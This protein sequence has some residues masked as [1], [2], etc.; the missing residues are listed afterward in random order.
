MASKK[1]LKMLTDH[2]GRLLEAHLADFTYDSGRGVL[3]RR[4]GDVEQVVQCL[5]LPIGGGISADVSFFVRH[6]A[7]EN[8]R[9]RANKPDRA[10]EH[11]Y[12]ASQSLVNL[13]K[14]CRKACKHEHGATS[15]GL[16]KGA[17]PMTEEAFLEQIA[18]QMVRQIRAWGLPYLKQYSD[19]RRLLH[20]LVYDEG[21][22]SATLFGGP[23]RAM[24]MLV[25]HALLDGPAALEANVRYLHDEATRNLGEH[26]I[27]EFDASWQRL[28]DTLESAPNP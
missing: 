17:V 2:M 12:T 10:P 27:P 8:I 4:R 1:R 23:P 15:W 22:A 13:D 6:D 26:V 24:V 28:V 16:E 18:L 3:V 21:P 25:L 19:A 20:D 11:T 14:R 5:A 9:N 7:V